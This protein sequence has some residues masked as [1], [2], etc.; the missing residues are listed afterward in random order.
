M[1]NN[2][3]IDL[4]SS[5]SPVGQAID[6]LLRSIG[7][8]KTSK[9]IAFLI[10]SMTIFILNI[11]LGIIVENFLFTSPSASTFG[12]AFLIGGIFLYVL[13]ICTVSILYL[14][15][16]DTLDE[17]KQY[18]EINPLRNVHFVPSTRRSD[19]TYDYDNIYR[20]MAELVQSTRQMDIASYWHSSDQVE[21][22]VRQ[23]PGIDE[24]YRAIEE[25]VE[26]KQFKYRR[27]CLYRPGVTAKSL[28]ASHAK[29]RRHFER[30]LSID[31]HCIKEQVSTRGSSPPLVETSF[32]VFYDEEPR[33]LPD[34]E[35]VPAHI[36]WQVE[37]ANEQSKIY[38]IGLVVMR[39]ETGGVARELFDFFSNVYYSRSATHINEDVLE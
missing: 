14:G 33:S 13:S 5:L 29:F 25:K 24:Y 32:A 37:S 11:L 36:V 23:S 19:G 8:N 15:T 17:T 21:M 6:E 18:V 2:D 9:R 27:L 12:P 30:M 1:N 20:K 16:L 4:I 7:W 39:D 26:A 3:Q 10:W 35:M 22:E 34:A 31:P 28:F 38:I